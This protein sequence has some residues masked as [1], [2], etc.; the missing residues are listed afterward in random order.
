VCSL[1]PC[2]SSEFEADSKVYSRRYRCVDSV[3]FSSMRDFRKAIRKGYDIVHVF[4]FVASGGLLEDTNGVTLLGSELIDECCKRDVKL[5]WIANGNESNEYVNGFKVAGKPLNLIMTLNRNGTNFAE[6]LDKLV[7]RVA[8]GQ[9]LP[10]AWTAPAPQAD[11]PWQEKLP[12]CIFFAG[13]ADAKL[14]A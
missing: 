9:T 8:V 3:S 4:S 10:A 13:R 12:S 6:F 2:F 1:D 7:S 5:L 11:G 14:L